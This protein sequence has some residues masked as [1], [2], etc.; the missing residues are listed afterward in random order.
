MFSTANNAVLGLKQVFGQLIFSGYDSSRFA[1]NAVSFTMTEDVTR[2]LVVVLKSITYKQSTS[3]TLLSNGINIFIDSTDPNLWLPKDTCTAFE[4][5]FGLQLDDTSGLYLVNETHH[6]TLV[7]SKAEVEFELSDVQTGGESVTITLPYAAFDLTAKSPLVNNTSYYF[8][9][10]VASDETKYTLGRTFLQEAYVAVRLS[11]KR[12]GALT[13]LLLIISRYLSA[14]YER[15]VFNVSACVWNEGAAQN[16]VTITSKDSD[17]SG[18]SEGGSKPHSRPSS[19]TIAG[20]SVGSV[21][22]VALI[23]VII[24]VFVRR[25]RRQSADCRFP[26]TLYHLYL[27]CF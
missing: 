8:P 14:D 19:S 21:V 22:A 2:D 6:K 3:E 17:T 23:A 16:I 20:I 1:E 15:K 5:A 27:T 24:F 13:S 12:E 25:K 18:D 9:L 11:L 7:D 26:I 10:K 4:K